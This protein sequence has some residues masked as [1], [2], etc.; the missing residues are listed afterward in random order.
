MK[1]LFIAFALLMGL[2]SCNSGSSTA[3]D[4]IPDSIEVVT[5]SIPS[6]SVVVDTPAFV[7]DT[8]Q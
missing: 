4:T 3:V 6:D 1:K 7:V 5:D 2:A 8:I